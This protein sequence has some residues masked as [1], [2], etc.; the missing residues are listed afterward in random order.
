MRTTARVR[1][2]CWP[3]LAVAAGCLAKPA[4]VPQMF[5]IDPP[6]VEEPRRS[7]G[8]Y[9]VSVKKVRVSPLFD[10]RD[11]IYRTGEHRLER[12]PYASFAAPPGDMLTGAVRAYLRNAVF[13]REVVEPGG[14][15]RPDLLVEVYAAEI[16]GDLRRTDDAA[17]VLTLRFLVTPGEADRHPGPPL[18]EKEYVSRIRLPRRSA[19]AIATAWNQGLSGVMKEFVGDL[20]AVLARAPPPAAPAACR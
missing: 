17:A 16:S 12:D 15:L 20:E 6:A 18:L 2:G 1:A 5:S 19:D 4:L 10:S 9:V 8:A 13:A 7:A 11:L 14:A 3:A